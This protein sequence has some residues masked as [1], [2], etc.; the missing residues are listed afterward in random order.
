M[1]GRRALANGFPFRRPLPLCWDII[2]GAMRKTLQAIY[3]NGVLRPLEPLG[4]KEHQQVVIEISE[5][6]IARSDEEWLDL[7]CLQQAA[8]EAD[9]SISLEAVREALAKIPGSLTADF[10]AERDER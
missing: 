2:K 7:D 9:D 5:V 6:P 10:I 4:L 1:G 8:S 3:E